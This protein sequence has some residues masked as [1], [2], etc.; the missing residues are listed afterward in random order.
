MNKTGQHP[1]LVQKHKKL[2]KHVTFKQNQVNTNLYKL[3]NSNILEMVPKFDSECRGLL[4]INKN[5]LITLFCIIVQPWSS[6]NRCC[7]CLVE[8]MGG[9]V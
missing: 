1:K 4:Q 6:L 8:F 5:C 7:C 9:L 2:P 3:N